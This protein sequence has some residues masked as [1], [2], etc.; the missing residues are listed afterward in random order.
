MAYNVLKG[1]I[2]GSVDQHGDQE[3]SG[4][5]V[6]KSTI[7]ASVFY[8][9]DAQSPCAT[10]KDVGILHIS[11][12]PHNSLL[13]YTADQTARA[14]HNL[15][16][17]KD[18][19]TV[20]KIVA[21]HFIG[22]GTLL[23][24]LP[25]DQFVGE[26]R[27]ENIAHGPGLNNV[28]GK[29]QI[30]AG[31]GIDTTADGVAVALTLK[32][33]LSAKDKYLRVDPA[34]A[35]SITEGGQNLSDGDMLLV[36]DESRASLHNTTLGNFYNK[37]ISAKIPQPAGQPNELQLKGKSGFNS[38]PHLSFDAGKATLTVGG[39]VDAS[40]IQAHG[41]LVCKGSVVKNIKRITEEKYYVADD[42]YTLLCDS[43]SNAITMT[44]PP[45]CNNRGRI[46][47]IKKVN[48]DKYNIRSFPVVV[49]VEEGIID[50]NDQ[51]TLKTNYSCRT[52]QSDGEN[53]W[54]I[55]AKGT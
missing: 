17:N 28:R 55:G 6:F 44:L 42:D 37:Y 14:P 51:I 2:E 39:T 26:I 8:D 29:L 16:F 21:N 4:I 20:P 54:V 11:G 32:S 35:P 36:G 24:E 41:A 48:T 49:T 47:N 30:N 12:T 5:K 25:V 18:E 7:S 23:K 15:T 1:T 50:L 9:T 53:W 31:L 19:L 22:K 34:C 13:V 10:L 52:L 3:I 45:A 40:N 27:A 33:G 38:S 46:L 43:Y